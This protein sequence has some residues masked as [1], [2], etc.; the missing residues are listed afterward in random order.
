MKVTVPVPHAH[1]VAVSL[2][3]L[4]G[5]AGGTA[6]LYPCDAS[7]PTIAHLPYRA[8]E[9]LAVSAFVPVSGTDTIC[10]HAETG[11]VLTADAP[12]VIVDVTGT[13]DNGGLRYVPVP[14]TR[15]LDTRQRH[16]RVDG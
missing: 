6:T 10:V 12:H 16:R 4:G 5:N 7:I 3:I 1:A 9:V 8:G 15:L 14:A 13:F 11:S 2:T